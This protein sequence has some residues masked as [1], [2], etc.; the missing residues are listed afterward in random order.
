MR[1]ATLTLAV[2]FALTLLNPVLAQRPGNLA[3][4]QPTIR[5]GN[6]AWS[7]GRS[8]GGVQRIPRRRPP[9]AAVTRGSGPRGVSTESFTHVRDDKGKE[10]VFCVPYKV[11]SSQ[12]RFHAAAVS[13]RKPL[14]DIVKMQHKQPLFVTSVF[15]KEM[16]LK[17]GIA[18]SKFKDPAVY[19]AMTIR[20]PFGRWLSFFL[21]H[22]VGV[23]RDK[24]IPDLSE[25]GPHSLVTSNLFKGK[26]AGQP[27][28][29]VSFDTLTRYLYACASKYMRPP[30]GMT[31]QQFQAQF[32]EARKVIKCENSRVLNPHLQGITAVCRPDLVPYND[33]LKLETGTAVT[34]L[35]RKAGMVDFVTP[36]LGCSMDNPPCMDDGKNP[37]VE[38]F[39]E[40]FMD[41][42]KTPEL[43][44]MVGD[45]YAADYQL[46]NYTK[47]PSYTWNSSWVDPSP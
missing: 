47:P 16:T 31:E 24:P 25:F 45:V 3:L 26:R 2:V 6:G 27:S 14:P 7:S 9:A 20:E 41:R 34:D 29:R 10:A 12:H 13:R 11:G 43:L 23:R 42:F 21:N 35:W 28:R 4:R 37:T 44:S 19:K 18:E 22:L 32:A 36:F 17:R 33:V 39:P 46:G 38:L 15:I 8:Q 5:Y 40:G 30:R 1:G